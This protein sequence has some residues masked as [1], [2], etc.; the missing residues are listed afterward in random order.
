MQLIHGKFFNI[1][2]KGNLAKN[3]IEILKQKEIQG[4]SLDEENGFKQSK[5]ACLLI[6]DRGVDLI[7]PMLTPFT[8]EAL[9]DE[10]FKIK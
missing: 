6:V 1:Y 5:L 9:I 8:Y 4:Q 2:A 10:Y 7:T 3:V